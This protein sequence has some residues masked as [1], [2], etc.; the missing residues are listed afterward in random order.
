MKLS[1]EDERYLCFLNQSNAYKLIEME[2]DNQLM[3]GLSENDQDFEKYRKCQKRQIM[4][5]TVL[6]A[7]MLKN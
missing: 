1:L 2:K 6:K 3:L 4:I 5:N 7:R